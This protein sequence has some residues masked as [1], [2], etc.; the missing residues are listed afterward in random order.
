[1][2]DVTKIKRPHS[3]SVHSLTPAYCSIL[4]RHVEAFRSALPSLPELLQIRVLPPSLCCLILHLHPIGFCPLS[5]PALLPLCKSVI[6]ILFLAQ[7]FPDE[8]LR[9]LAF[10]Q[11][12]TQSITWHRTKSPQTQTSNTQQTHH[13]RKQATLISK[14]SETSTTR[15]M[16]SRASAADGRKSGALSGLAARGEG[17]VGCA[18]GVG[19]VEESMPSKSDARAQDL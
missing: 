6:L 14:I 16:N 3:P 10:I 17:V 7:K 11:I 13:T 18:A 2:H 9:S 12:R 15:K 19:S 8:I 4:S 5:F 1:L